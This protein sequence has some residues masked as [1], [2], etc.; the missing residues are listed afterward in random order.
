MNQSRP[1][2]TYETPRRTVTI[3]RRY[4]GGQPIQE[5]LRE[6]LSAQIERPPL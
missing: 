3:E 5:L 2:T 4:V 1:D 6:L